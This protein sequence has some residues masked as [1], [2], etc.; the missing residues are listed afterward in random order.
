[1]IK[2]YFC[3]EN[4]I[5]KTLKEALHPHICG[6]YAI[7]YG[8][9]GKPYIQGNPVF[10]SISHSGDEGVAL[11]SDRQCGVDLEVLKPRKIDAYYCRLSERER[12][13]IKEDYKLFLKNWVAKEAYIKDLGGTVG[14]IKRLE[15]AGGGRDFDGKRVD[16]E[17][18]VDTDSGRAVYAVCTGETR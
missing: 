14:W 12:A 7:K 13:E 15:Y 5:E 16:G 1:M 6:N 17:I 4:E 9:Y 2:L 8:D 3:R 18:K 10:F 11:I